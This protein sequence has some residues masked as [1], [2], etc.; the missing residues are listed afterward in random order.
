MKKKLWIFSLGGNEVS[1]MDLKDPKTGKPVT[2]DIPL[3]WQRTVQTLRS[4]ADVIE[5]RP[6]D[7]Y[8][9]THGNGPQVGN[10]LL[11]AEYARGI[12]HTLPLDICG[13]DSQGAMGYMLAQLSNE[14]RMRGVNKV[15]A[16]TVTQVVVNPKDPDFQN[17]SKFIGSQLSRDE[18]EDRRRKD[19]WNVK[20]YGTDK[21]GKEIWRRVVPSP[22]PMDI[23]EIDVVEAQLKAGVI[24]I[25][26]GGGGIPVVNVEPRLDG[27]EEV[28]EC[29]YGITFKRPQRPGEKP[30]AIRS[31]VEAVIDKDLATSL[32]GKML[33]ERARA[34]GEELEAHFA[35][36]THEDGVKLDY[37]KPTQ[38]DLR[39]LTLADAKATV[40]K[41]P[42]SFPAGSMGPKMRAVIRFLEAG[43]TAAYITKTEL[44]SKTLE[45]TA[46]TT[47]TR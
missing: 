29:N 28:Y 43:G 30:A 44:F 47:V 36:F 31:G 13:A 33:I 10:I 39:K 14:L 22:D 4:I 38:K 17:P 19:G 35:I 5:K 7:Y 34:K 15:V 21:E 9:L 25:S 16:E 23:V 26:V 3:Q 42:E 45:G 32:L 40:E 6:N 24:P 18:A 12:L 11:R 1:P 37:K 20:L 41:H 8:L 27:G 46:G 2:P